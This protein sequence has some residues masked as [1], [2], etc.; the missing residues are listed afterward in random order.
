MRISNLKLGT[1]GV[2]VMDEEEHYCK[3][4]CGQK[5]AIKSYHK[6]MGIPSFIHG[7]NSRM[8]GHFVPIHNVKHSEESKQKMSM[9]RKLFVGELHPFYGKKHSTEAK[10]KISL[11]RI[12]RFG[13]ENNPFFGKH[14]SG[15]MKLVQSEMRKKQ[16][17]G[18]GNPFFGKRHTKQTKEKISVKAIN[19]WKTDKE[20]TERVYKSLCVKPNRAE[21]Q[22]SNILDEIHPGEWKYTGDFSLIM[23][24][25][26]PDFVNANGK[27]LIIELFGERWH[28]GETQEDRAKYFSP[29]GYRTLVI[30][31]KELSDKDALIN[32]IERFCKYDCN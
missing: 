8:P 31:C 25:K 6:R 20:F 1:N 15:E 23:N 2:A 21:M 9:A 29:L 32:K 4:G 27:K 14:H 7:H 19:R 12:G 11:S 18:E 16:Y 13:G 30:W 26:C 28:E 5:I 3:C 10:R 24:G 17:E 22:L